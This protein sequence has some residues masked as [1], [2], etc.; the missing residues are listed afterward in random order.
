MLKRRKECGAYLATDGIHRC[1]FSWWR[2]QCR[3]KATSNHFSSSSLDSSD[4]YRQ[5][6]GRHHTLSFFLTYFLSFYLSRFSFYINN[7]LK[8]LISIVFSLDI[9]FFL[10]IQISLPHMRIGRA[11]VLYICSLIDFWVNLG[12]KVLF[13]IPKIWINSN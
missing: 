3:L 11:N 5:L 8:N 7:L 10:I 2:P 12:F 13:I 1:L 6:P 4:V 9:S